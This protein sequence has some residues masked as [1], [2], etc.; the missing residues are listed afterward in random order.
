MGKMIYSNIEVEK[1]KDS[2][3]TLFAEYNASLEE[4]ERILDETKSELRH[5]RLR[6]SGSNITIEL[7]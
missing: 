7:K 3:L 4:I 5:A 6:K 1:I 2:I